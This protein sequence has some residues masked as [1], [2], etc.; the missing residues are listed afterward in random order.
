MMGSNSSC[1]VSTREGEG[2]GPG[3]VPCRGHLRGGPLEGAGLRFRFC[4]RCPRIFLISLLQVGRL[5]GTRWHLEGLQT[6]RQ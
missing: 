1:G 4:L 5:G 2:Q 6:Q 3:R